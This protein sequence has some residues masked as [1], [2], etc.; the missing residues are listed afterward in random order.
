MLD[1]P[2]SIIITTTI[3]II[4]IIFPVRRSHRGV[5]LFRSSNGLNLASRPIWPADYWLVGRLAMQTT[6][7]LMTMLEGSSSNS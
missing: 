2:E 3:I 7:P 4:M 6:Y 5:K 1:S